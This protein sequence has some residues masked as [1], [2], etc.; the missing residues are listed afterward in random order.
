MSI[1]PSWKAIVKWGGFS[2]FLAGVI[3]IIFMIGIGAFQVTLPLDAEE[4]LEDPI[5]PTSLFTI[6]L[7]GEFLL[8]PGFLALYF[9]LRDDGRVKTFLL[10]A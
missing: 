6:T 10:T 4:V 7:I 9:T 8:F 5:V 2:L 3:V 1:D